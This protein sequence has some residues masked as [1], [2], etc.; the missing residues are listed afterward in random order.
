MKLPRTYIDID[1]EQKML[2]I[3]FKNT[4]L[5]GENGIIHIY[6]IHIIIVVL[7]SAAN[8]IRGLGVLCG[9]GSDFSWKKPTIAGDSP[10]VAMDHLFGVMLNSNEK[11][12]KYLKWQCRIQMCKCLVLFIESPSYPRHPI[13]INHHSIMLQ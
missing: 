2:S 6:Y 9:F 3:N 4:K 8:R 7:S 1:A 5:L 13:I 11:S 10:Q 12:F